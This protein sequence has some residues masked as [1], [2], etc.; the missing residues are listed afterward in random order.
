MTDTKQLTD[1]ISVAP[2]VPPGEVA[3]LAGRYRTLINNRPDGEEPGQARSAEIEEAAHAAGMDYVHI[4]IVPGQISSAQVAAFDDAL[5][6]HPGPMLAFCRSGTRSTAM[7]ALSQAGKR[8]AD[9]IL[10][11]AKAAGYDLSP[12]R[13]TLEAKPVSG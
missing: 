6:Q 2:F 11:T 4:P 5:T 8:S 7:W 12:L 1:E 9:D 10:A 3:A 13:P